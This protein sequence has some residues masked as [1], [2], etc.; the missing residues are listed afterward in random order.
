[1]VNYGS[2][3][4]GDVTVSANETKKNPILEYTNLTVESGVTLTLPSRVRLMVT[5]TLT[6]NGTV[7]VNRDISG[8]GANGAKSGG[9]LEL[10]AKEIVGNGEINV[11]GN[12]AGDGNNWGNRNNG[13][14]GAGYSIPA[15]SKNGSGG[16]G[17]GKGADAEYSNNWNGNRNGGGGG[18]AHSSI[19]N[20]STLKAY[21]EDYLLSGAY[22]TQSPIDTMLPGSGGGAGGGGDR[23]LRR[24]DNNNN[25]TYRSR[26]EVGGGGGGAGGSFITKGGAA[27]N[28]DE[29]Y[30]TDNALSV[31]PN[32]NNNGDARVYYEGGEGGGGG[33]AGGFIL[34]VSEGVDLS[35]TFSVRGGDGG[36][37]YWGRR[38]G[39]EW[40]GNNFSNFNEERNDMDGGGG[41][42]GAGGLIIGF[43]DKTPS[44]DLSGGT[45]G[46]PGGQRRNGANNNANAGK[47]GEDGATFLY[48][49]SELK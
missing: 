6:V 5:D 22:I 13:G 49:V 12:N 9:N 31:E 19:Y 26:I 39:N 24:Y 33:G 38:H 11:D 17:G 36:D 25:S 30:E 48:D 47:E 2:G 29:H 8:S 15:T 4:L 41:G 1:M 21:I 46:I 20:D 44:I 43:T 18:N 37:G 7:R 16:S 42:G 40:D 14:A 32:G 27:G 45:R 35:V 10:F 3:Q 34:L 23:Q 28:G